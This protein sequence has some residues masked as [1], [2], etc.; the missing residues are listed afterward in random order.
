MATRLHATQTEFMAAID[1]I[2][3]FVAEHD[4]PFDRQGDDE[5]TLNLVGRW[6]DFHVWFSWRQHQQALNFACAFDLKIPPAKR[7][8]MCQLVILMNERL[9]VGHFDIWQEEGMVL[10]RHALPLRGTLGPVPEQVEDLIEIALTES[11]RF[12]PAVQFVMWGDYTPQRALDGALMETV[13][14]A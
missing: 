11:E 8:E 2:E 13:G 9:S 7:A 3:Q 10:Y 1:V 4:W 5:L 14:Q 6:C 12:Y